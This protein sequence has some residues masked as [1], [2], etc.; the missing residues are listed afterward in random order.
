MAFRTI[1]ATEEFHE[2]PVNGQDEH[3]SSPWLSEFK[4][5]EY[6]RAATKP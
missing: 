1:A 5:P 2:I 3:R 6:G 4:D